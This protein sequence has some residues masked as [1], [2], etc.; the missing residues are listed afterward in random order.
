MPRF[1]FFLYPC[2]GVKN[3]ESCLDGINRDTRKVSRWSKSFSVHHPL[4]GVYVWLVCDCSVSSLTGSQ[5]AT[6]E[7][8]SI[9]TVLSRSSLAL[10]ELQNH[11]VNTW[12][13]RLVILKMSVK[14]WAIA[15]AEILPVPCE[16]K[17]F[18]KIIPRQRFFFLCQ[19]NAAGNSPKQ[20]AVDLTDFSCIF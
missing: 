5:T 6:Q 15:Q 7:T 1:K 9:N 18:Q 4:F 11:N 10:T 17:R 13:H 12:R 16:R 8:G 3:T 14:L 19:W 20:R 2:K